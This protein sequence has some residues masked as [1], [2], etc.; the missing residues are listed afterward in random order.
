[1]STVRVVVVDDSVSVRHALRSALGQEP[2]LEIVGEA[3]DGQE[4]VDV[5]RT[6]Q[7]DAVVLDVELPVMDGVHAIPHIQHAAPQATIAMLTSH[8]DNEQAA[9]AAGADAFFMKGVNSL[10][11][12]AHFL[13]T[14]CDDDGTVAVDEEVVD[15]VERLTDYEV[16][17][18]ESEAPSP[19]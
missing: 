4:G 13:A 11:D 2:N 16:P 17:V 18:S 15:L 8:P 1:M 7:P 5:C 10:E 3:A 9:V 19:A 14:A 12:V 6:A